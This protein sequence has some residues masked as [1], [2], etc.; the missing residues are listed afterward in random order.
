MSGDTRLFDYEL[1][2]DLIAQS[3]ASPREAAKLMVVNRTGK[4]I[5]RKKVSSLPNYFQPGDLIV[6][7]NTK[8]F[9]ARLLGEI[10]K[11]KNT[12]VELFLLKPKSESGWHALVKPGKKCP[13]GT[14]ITIKPGL[15]ATVNKVNS[16]GSVEVRLNKP[17][18][19]LLAFTDKYGH[20][21]VPPYIKNEPDLRLYQTSY[22][23]IT[24]SVA[25]PTAGFH[26]TEKIRREII[27]KGAEIS[28]ITLHVGLGTFRPVKT[29]HVADHQMAPEWVSVS[30]EAA[31]KINQANKENRRVVAVGTTTVRTL[32]GVA[33]MNSGMMMP[34]EGDVNL[35]I[36][37]GFSFKVIKALLTNFHLPK[38]TLII[39]VSA[40]AGRELTMK[41]YET[42]VK[43][44]FRFYSFGDAMLIV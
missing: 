3:P 43:Q 8:V 1:P 27:H 39:L 22:A 40:F 28:E 7:N 21:P 20:V 32:E 6:V 16:D 26:L 31:Q 17:T 9:K 10:K 34:Y 23:K 14:E 29:D 33:K 41:A 38:S 44:K 36:R 42:A 11:E 13:V 24:G 19:R 4:T 5:D 2:E 12:R 37:P 30:H 15:K 18:G 35:F 25:A